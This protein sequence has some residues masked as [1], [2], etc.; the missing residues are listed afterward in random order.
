MMALM[1]LQEVGVARNHY[2]KAILGITATASGLMVLFGQNGSGTSSAVSMVTATPLTS[3]L[4]GF[5]TLSGSILQ[6]DSVQ[7]SA[8]VYWQSQFSSTELA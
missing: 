8:A 5:L 2:C 1:M 6:I 4:L 7:A 3:D